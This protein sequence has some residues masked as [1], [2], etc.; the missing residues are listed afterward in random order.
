MKKE[1]EAVIQQSI[2][3]WFNNEYCLKHHKPRLIIHSVPNGIPIHLP[4][5]EMSRALDLM[6]KT[7]MVN[8]ISDMIIQGVCGRIINVEVKN[9]IGIQSPA[10]KNIETRVQELGGTYILV[11][12]LEQFQAEIK[13]HL[14]YLMNP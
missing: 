3:C 4:P 2:F 13:K 1:S 9:Y 14:V 5:N 7:G 11:R 12:N 10:Q 6:L 8:G